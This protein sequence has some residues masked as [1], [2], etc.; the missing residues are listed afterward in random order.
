MADDNDVRNMEQ[1]REHYER[2]RT[3]ITADQK[4]A[5]RAAAFRHIE[6]MVADIDRRVA[7]A[8]RCRAL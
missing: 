1:A 7:D 8:L 6:Q 3:A 5:H 4:T 2:A